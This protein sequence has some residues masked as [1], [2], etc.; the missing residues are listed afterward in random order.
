M[1]APITAYRVFI[2]SPGGLDD[3]RQAFRRTFQEHNEGPEAMG[4]SVMF[5]PIGWEATLGRAGR[6]QALIN[7][8][9]R[10]CDYFILVMH[11]KWG[12]R[13][14]KGG[15]AGGYTS[16]SEEEFEIAREC[17]R[18]GSMRDM[19]VFFRN[20]DREKL[21]DPGPE[22][23]KVIDFQTRLEQEKEFLYERFDDVPTF[24][25][26]LRAHMDSWIL[27]HEKG[28][29]EALSRPVA[30][31]EPPE[32]KLAAPPE[33]EEV[34][35]SEEVEN[36]EQLAEQ[37][38][39]IEA[40][41]A[42]AKAIAGEE[43]LD[44]MSRYGAMLTRT[45]SLARALEVFQELRGLATEQGKLQWEV[46]SISNIAK[47]HELEGRLAEAEKGYREALELR[48][49]IGG[50]HHPDVAVS[51]FDLAGLYRKQ[52][53]YQEAIELLDRAAKIQGGQVAS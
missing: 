22:L 46:A 20:F 17:H 40:E 34:S 15:A 2:A 51:L 32:V 6:P 12:S 14:Q 27:A 42:F 50:P 1:P 30:R 29:Q 38:K 24:E 37:G 39:V 4:R 52:A 16:G 41:Q 36:A 3:V 23:R 21:K 10:Q 25:K 35:S 13:T 53:R 18:A 7:E 26:R 33:A 19:V 5:I 31:R 45:G 28:T 44:A 9:L 11:E 8:D 49:K 43:D 48:E 47:I